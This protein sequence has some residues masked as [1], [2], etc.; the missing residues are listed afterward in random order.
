MKAFGVE[1]TEEE[2]AALLKYFDT[3]KSGKISLNEMLHAMRSSSLNAR[4]EAIIE[5]AYNKL[6]R[7]GN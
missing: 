1:I 4:R 2:M 7:N 3:S 5:A 6:D